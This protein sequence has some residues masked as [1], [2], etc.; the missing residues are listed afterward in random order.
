M[1]D[2]MKLKWVVT[3]GG[4]PGCLWVV[5]SLGMFLLQEIFDKIDKEKDGVIY[6]RELVLYMR[7]MNEEIDRNLQVGRTP[8]RQ[9]F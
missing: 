4:G 5:Y 6:L 2:M 3:L 8:T 9:Y 7:A 1:V